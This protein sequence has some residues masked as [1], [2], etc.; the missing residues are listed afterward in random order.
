MAWPAGSIA[1]SPAPGRASSV[2]VTGRRVD[3]PAG[4]LAGP[5]GSAAKA[6]AALVSTD[7]NVT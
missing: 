7:A 4:P 3:T 5:G 1:W 6:I 2:E